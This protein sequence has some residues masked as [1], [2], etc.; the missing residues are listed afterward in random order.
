V[1]RT[2]AWPKLSVPKFEEIIK[3]GSHAYLFFLLLF[4]FFQL[5]QA[6]L[7]VAGSELNV[8][9]GRVSGNLPLS[10]LLFFA[11]LLFVFFA[12]SKRSGIQNFKKL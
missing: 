9:I 6:L 12:Q 10:F 1:P 2:A 4:P 7:F 3:L 11:F 5:F 8:V